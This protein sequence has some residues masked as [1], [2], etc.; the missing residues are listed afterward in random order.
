MAQERMMLP[1]TLTLTDRRQL[2]MTG[3][4][5]VVSFDESAILLRTDQGDLLIQGTD[6]QLKSLLPDSGQITVD[7]TVSA[8]SY[9]QP[10]QGGWLRR[11]MK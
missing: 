5:E 1:H 11:M 10:R 4:T 3:V 9:E 2:S 6:L 8:L 7:G